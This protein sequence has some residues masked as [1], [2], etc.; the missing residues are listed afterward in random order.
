MEALKWGRESLGDE[1]YRGKEDVLTARAI[2][3]RLCVMS[4]SSSRTGHAWTSCSWLTESAALNVSINA[5]TH[6][7][8]KSNLHNGRQKFPNRLKIALRDIQTP[9]AFKYDGFHKYILSECSSL[10]GHRRDKSGRTESGVLVFRV[11]S[12]YFYVKN[13]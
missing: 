1:A 2:A 6:L 4:S 8:Y 10:K 7:V 13:E 3:I 5:S 11:F 9:V 12:I